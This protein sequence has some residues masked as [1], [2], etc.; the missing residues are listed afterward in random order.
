MP[1]VVGFATQQIGKQLG[2][3]ECTRLVE[4]A[5]TQA[6]FKTA[7]DFGVVGN[8][9]DYVWGTLVSLDAARP[10]DIIQFRNHEMEV[11]KVKDGSD[12]S[13]TVYRRPHHSAILMGKRFRTDDF[14]R[15]YW[16]LVI[17]EQN[18]AGVRH[19]VKSI[20]QLQKS[21]HVFADGYEK[22]VRVSGSAKIYHPVP[23]AT[24]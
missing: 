22:Q 10:G 23:L 14:N 7:V 6:G 24:P 4:Q 1:G 5:L 18:Q 13:A 15:P 16:E 11:W 17:Y 19:V 2:D 21:T 3:G 8:N 9:A 20:I 12:L